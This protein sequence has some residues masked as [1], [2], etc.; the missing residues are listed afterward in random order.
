MCELCGEE[1]TEIRRLKK[2]EID[3]DD[4]CEWMPEPPDLEDEDLDEED[5]ESKLERCAERPV[6]LV[7]MDCVQEH[8]CAVH[9][10]KEQ[11]DMDAGL[12]NFLEY[13][14]FD[15]GELRPIKAEDEVCEYMDPDPFDES[16][17]SGPAQFARWVRHEFV[18]CDEH[19]DEYREEEEED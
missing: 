17:C 18:I 12:A 6:W 3:L 14:G 16:E 10:R 9:A 1:K 5:Y 15:S 11:A 13:A 4:V 2:H 8:L 19:I 7:V